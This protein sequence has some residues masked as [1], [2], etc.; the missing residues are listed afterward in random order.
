[1][2]NKLKLIILGSILSIA[3]GQ[4]ETKYGIGFNVEINGINSL[5]QLIESGDNSSVNGIYFPIEKDGYLF[6]PSVSY[7]TSSTL[8]DYNEDSFDSERTESNI[9]AL[10]GLFKL[11]ERDK[12]R[13]KA[14]LRTGKTW[15]SEKSKY[16]NE[17]EEIDKSDLL[18]LSPT[19]GAEYFISPHFSFGGEAMF[20]ITNYKVD[21]EDNNNF[22]SDD[23][24]YTET[25]KVNSLNHKFI[26]RYYF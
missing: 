10:L 21:G 14:G 26:L 16:S 1:M 19:I 8:K 23:L 11:Y 12:V 9:T 17:D 4:N 13:F 25:R 18:I 2:N 3:F 7:M 20:S 24:T 22:S 6:E 15:F 5:I